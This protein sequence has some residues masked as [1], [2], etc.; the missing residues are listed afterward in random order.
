MEAVD[1]RVIRHTEC[2]VNFVQIKLPFV[3]RNQVRISFST[4]APSTPESFASSP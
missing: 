4:F 3:I 2:A 1:E